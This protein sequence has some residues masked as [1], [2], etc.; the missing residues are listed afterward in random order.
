MHY[1]QT[2]LH[3]VHTSFLLDYFILWKKGLHLTQFSL[4]FIFFQSFNKMFTIAFFWIVNSDSI[5]FTWHPKFFIVTLFANWQENIS[6][7]HFDVFS[8]LYAA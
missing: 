7:L 5:M 8:E 4:T 6:W 3:T 2:N 1:F